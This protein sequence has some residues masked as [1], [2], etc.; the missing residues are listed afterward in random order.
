[1]P[2]RRRFLRGGWQRDQKQGE[3]RAAPHRAA[4]AWRAKRWRRKSAGVPP[5][6]RITEDDREGWLEYLGEAAK[7]HEDGLAQFLEE[8]VRD[9]GL[10]VELGATARERGV[11][12]AFG[13]L[14][15]A[16]GRI[17]LNLANASGAV[18]NF[19]ARVPVLGFNVPEALILRSNA[20]SNYHGAQFS[21]TKRLSQGLQF[22]VAY[23]FS[24]SIDYNSQSSQ[25][26]T[27]QDSYNLRNSR[28]LSDFDARH[29]FVISG[30]YELP[31]HG[32]QFKEG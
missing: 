24:K 18:I 30:L 17:D 23:T 31:F 3:D 8:L 22:N 6:R 15:P 27:V 28:G 2:E 21:L 7:E 5:T 20:Y 11:G 32:N 9:P 25:G 14:N 29:R 10:A 26:V 13:F 16:T 12:R 1:M 19:E 4:S